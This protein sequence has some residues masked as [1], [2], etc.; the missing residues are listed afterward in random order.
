[1]AP[2]TKSVAYHSTRRRPNAGDRL[3]KDIPYASNRLQH[4]RR[5]RFVDLFAQPA[6]QH[7]NDVRLRIEG[8][9]PDMGENH[10]LGHNLPS[11]SHQVLE[12]R[13]LAR[14]KIDDCP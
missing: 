12:K 9:V 8:V 1:M 10:G 4:L 5:E 3:T 2:T 11:V 6:H 14:G 13:E 7:V